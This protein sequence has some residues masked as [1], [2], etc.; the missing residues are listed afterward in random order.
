[1]RAVIKTGA[2]VRSARATRRDLLF[3]TLAL[4]H[5]LGVLARS[6]RRFRQADR[7]FWLCLRWFW[8]RWREA[9]VLIQPAT[10]DR[11]RRE[12]VVRCWRRRSRRPGRPRIDSTSRDLIRR[13]AAENCLWGAPRIHGELLKLG[14]TISERTVSR[15]LRGHPTTRS[16]TWRTF[17]A[18]H[19][20]RQILISPVMFADAHDE[21]IIVD[22]SF[23]P[24]PS[25]D[26][27]CASIHRPSVDW[28]R[29]LQ[30]S[31]VGASLGQNRLHDH[32]EARKSCGRDPPR[33]LP[34]QPASPRPRRF[35]FV[36]G[37]SAFATEGSVRS[38]CPR[39]AGHLQFWVSTRTCPESCGKRKMA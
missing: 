19:L 1:M 6:N 4:R 31:S 7:L 25:I 26:A 38:I 13:M 20:A 37:D 16:Q 24:T 23:R 36:C 11:W 35:S 14:I 21:D 5:Q 22:L 34:L 18:N 15:Y 30:P 10:V 29:P 8:P 27:S 9:L 12:G 28:G 32:T 39:V 33:H 17:F 3:E 2:A